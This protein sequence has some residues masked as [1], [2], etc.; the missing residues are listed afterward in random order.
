SANTVLDAS[1]QLLTSR[2]VPALAGGA[3]SA[4]SATVTLPPTSG[5]G[6]YYLIAK[7]DADNAVQ[8][9]DETNNTT[10][11]AIQIGGDLTV[12]ALTVQVTSGGGLVV[13]DTT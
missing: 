4:V 2:Q 13:T 12:S 7:A 9:T 10:T 3:S 5:V 11:R 1:D 6:V 8:E